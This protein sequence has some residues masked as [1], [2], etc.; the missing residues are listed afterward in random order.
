LS[1]EPFDLPQIQLDL[2]AR[3]LPLQ[4]GF[5]TFRLTCDAAEDTTPCCAATLGASATPG[6]PCN[7]TWYCDTFIVQ[8]INLKLN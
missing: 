8:V 3:A 4:D 6:I 1:I 5:D 7:T 2:V